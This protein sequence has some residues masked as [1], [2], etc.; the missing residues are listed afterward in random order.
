MSTPYPSGSSNIKPI[1]LG[2]DQTESIELEATA[3]VT[4]TLMI[5]GDPD[6]LELVLVNLGANDVYFG[7]KSDVS[8]AKGIKISSGGGQVILQRFYDHSLTGWPLWCVSAA[9][10]SSIYILAVR[11][12]GGK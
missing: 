2:L 4:P 1:H 10:T 5:G 7:P 12:Y 6:R 9:G 11:R 3:G 8:T